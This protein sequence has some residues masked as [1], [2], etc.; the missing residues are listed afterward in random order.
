MSASKRREFLQAFLEWMDIN[1]V[2]EEDRLLFEKLGNKYL[3]ELKEIQ[4]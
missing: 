2:A 3:K 1:G 4:K